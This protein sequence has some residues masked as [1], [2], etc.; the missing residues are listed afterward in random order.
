MVDFK[1]FMLRLWL[2]VLL[3]LT[4]CTSIRYVTTDHG[5]IVTDRREPV[6][7]V[8]NPPVACN[9]V[10]FANVYTGYFMYQDN[11]GAIFLDDYKGGTIQ[12]QGDVVCRLLDEAR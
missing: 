5:R 11:D 6:V 10:G 8:G 7:I 3:A 1:S 2:L 4:G 12:L 9:L